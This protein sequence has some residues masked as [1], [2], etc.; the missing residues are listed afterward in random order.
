MT[1]LS[2]AD[3]VRVR[4]RFLRSANVE[5]D[6]LARAVTDYVPTGRSLDVLGR[7]ARAMQF[8]A[9]GRAISITGPYGS[10]KSS[11]AL[12]LEALLGPGTDA[13]N[14]QALASI[15]EVA[16]GLADELEVGRAAIG[17]DSLGFVRAVATARLE[18]VEQTIARALERGLV[19]YV[20]QFPTAPAAA[21]LKL[22]LRDLRRKTPQSNVGD[23]VLRAA[24]V[25]PIFILID[26]FGKNLE[27]FASDGSTG[28][29]DLYVLQELA[30]RASRPDGL[31]L[32][33]VTL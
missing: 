14:A 22:V 30:E 12:F 19:D 27:H 10:G 25:A 24:G 11:L 32:M 7:V 28:Q 6:D 23:L 9:T 4:Q 20:K 3:I 15:R 26:E 17:A 21:A 31:P 1:A 5:H 33:L 8:P 18:P 29:G 2:L 16:S 13:A